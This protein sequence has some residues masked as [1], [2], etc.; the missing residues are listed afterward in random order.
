MLLVE[1]LQGNDM[2]DDLIGLLIWVMMFGF[3]LIPTLVAWFQQHDQL[4]AIAALNLL[5]GWTL[6]GW[7]G[8]LVWVLKPKELRPQQRKKHHRKQ[9][10]HR[11]STARTQPHRPDAHSDLARRLAELRE[12]SALRGRGYPAGHN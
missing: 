10:H 3:Y 2:D 7:F 11:Q 9:K 8:A 5:L 12:V 6:L 4:Y 1:P